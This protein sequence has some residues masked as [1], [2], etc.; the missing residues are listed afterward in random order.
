MVAA[1]CAIFAPMSIPTGVVPITLAT[2]TAITAGLLLR[3]IPAAVSQ[4]V[5]IMLGVVGLPVFSNW[6]SGIGMVIGATGGFILAFPVLSLTVSLSV[7]LAK[8][9]M[10]SPVKLRIFAGIGIL[11]GLIVFFTAGAWRWSAFTAASFDETLAF[12]SGFM[13]GE[14][15]KMTF[16]LIFIV[17]VRQ[18]LK[19]A[20]PQLF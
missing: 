5:Y 19:T 18:R 12:V 1:I 17:P 13:A 20:Y 14:A 9:H 2:L 8:N 6:R 10:E 7:W 4:L 15:V 16:A 11:L 3:P